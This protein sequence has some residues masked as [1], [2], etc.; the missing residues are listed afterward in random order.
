MS[1]G[2]GWKCYFLASTSTLDDYF[3]VK[4]MQMLRFNGEHDEYSG[5]IMGG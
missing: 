2:W 4:K 3:L 5:P 1:K